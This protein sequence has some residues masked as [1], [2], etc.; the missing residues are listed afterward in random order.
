MVGST[1]KY[2]AIS[3]GKKEMG[4]LTTHKYLLSLTLER[5]TEIFF[6]STKIIN[7]ILK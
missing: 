5:A 6:L 7:L 3:I 2:F 4:S 1:T